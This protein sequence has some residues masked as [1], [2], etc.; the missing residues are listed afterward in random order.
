MSSLKYFPC[1]Q[2]KIT[3]Q[4]V[5]PS[6]ADTGIYEQ[7]ISGDIAFAM[8]QYLHLTNDIDWLR[9]KGKDVVYGIAKFWSSRVWK[10]PMTGQ[11]EV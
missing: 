4:Q 3:V 7:H 2:L 8:R 9:N 5:T 6:W 10:N 1:L 11:Y